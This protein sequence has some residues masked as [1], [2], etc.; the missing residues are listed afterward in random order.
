MATGEILIEPGCAFQGYSWL[1]EN[2]EDGADGNSFTGL[3]LSTR[4]W[5]VSTAWDRPA[6]DLTALNM[7]DLILGSTRRIKLG[8]NMTGN[9]KRW[10]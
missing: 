10:A 6:D 9:F 7:T 3:R 2:A 8:L 5:G 1:L 4:V